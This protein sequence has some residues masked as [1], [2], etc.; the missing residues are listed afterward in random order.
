MGIDTSREI[1]R[2]EICHHGRWS[3]DT[4][5]KGCKDIAAAAIR[6]E[7]GAKR[8][9]NIL[10]RL[11]PSAIKFRV[12]KAD[13]ELRR[14]LIAKFGQK[15]GPERETLTDLIIAGFSPTYALAAQKKR[16]PIYKILT[17]MRKEMES[18]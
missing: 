3:T 7:E 1:V 17:A 10:S 13:P 5:C 9:D 4:E 6:K 15:L 18:C 11:E 16:R 12:S 8:R 2:C 14:T